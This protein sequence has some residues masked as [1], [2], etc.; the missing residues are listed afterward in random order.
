M[1]AFYSTDMETE[2]RRDAYIQ[3]FKKPVH[4]IE[5][6]FNIF[7]CFFCLINAPM[8]KM[9]PFKP[10]THWIKAPNMDWEK[11]TTTFHPSSFLLDRKDLWFYSQNLLGVFL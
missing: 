4:H 6:R 10:F 1:R 9:E 5:S 11:T 7:V 8:N 3:T 2:G